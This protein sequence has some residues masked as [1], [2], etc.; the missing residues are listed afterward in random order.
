[1]KRPATLAL[2]A[3]LVVGCEPTLDQR[4]S[5]IDAPRVLAVISEPAETRPQQAASHR[6]WIASSQGIVS[7]DVTWAF[8]TEPKPPTEDN[9]VNARCLADA[10]RVIGTGALITAT[11]PSDACMRFGPDISDSTFRP[12]DPD[13]TGGYYQPLRLTLPVE[14]GSQTELAFASHRIGC[15]LANA[16]AQVS[17]DY[18]ERYVGNRNPP[19]PE[20]LGVAGESPWTMRVGERV[21]LTASWTDEAAET[22]LWFD[23]SDGQLRDR[24]ESLRLS[25]YGTAG[26]FCSDVTGRAEGERETFTENCWRAPM[27]PGS[28]TLWLV[29]RDSRGGAALREVSVEVTP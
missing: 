7:A 25:W 14:L 4:L 3:M 12:R 1:M 28:V 2:L 23:R 6:V 16:P 5:L 11:T 29:L 15:G 20:L 19:A 18:R 26:S 13:G 9:V 17:R 22:Y 10:V 24:R 8:C 27:Q 21:E